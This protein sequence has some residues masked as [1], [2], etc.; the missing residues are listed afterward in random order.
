M[1]RYVRT[2]PAS[3][4]YVK[5]LLLAGSL[6]KDCSLQAFIYS[7]IQ[8]KRMSGAPVHVCGLINFRQIS[9]KFPDKLFC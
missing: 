3:K 2:V 7:C 8:A 9:D 1:Y 5:T 4:Y 6:H